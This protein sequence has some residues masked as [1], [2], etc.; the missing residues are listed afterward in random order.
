MPPGAAAGNIG[1]RQRGPHPP[2]RCDLRPAAAVSR[3]GQESVVW[4][5][6]LRRAERLPTSIPVG[7]CQPWQREDS[8][9]L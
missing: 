4:C 2:A 9:G 8:G 1:P 5:K 3:G 6:A 7:R